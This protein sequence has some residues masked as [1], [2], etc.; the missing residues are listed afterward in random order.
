MPKIS[1]IMAT[2]NRAH[3]LPRA[4]NSVINQT[5]N[6]WELIIINDG[7]T[8]N[9]NNIL[10]EFKDPRIKIISYY[11]NRG[12]A[13]ARNCGLDKMKGEWFTILDS[14]DE[15]IPNALEELLSVP[16]IINKDINAVTCNCID[17]VSGE[18]TGK[19]L[20]HN[21]W[22]NFDKMV[23]LCYGEYWG[24]TKAELLGDLRFNIN[25]PWGE[26]VLWYKL[27]KRAIRY[28]IHKGLRIYH[29]EGTDRLSSKSK[30]SDSLINKKL[31]YYRNIAKE[32]EYLNILKKYRNKEYSEII[33]RVI[34]TFIADSNKNVRE[35]FISNYKFLNF[36][37]ICIIKI[38]YFLGSKIFKRILI[39]LLKNK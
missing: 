12:V 8:D 37:K 28:Y 29:T 17:S 13:Y 3:T 2:Y 18:M 5:F 1:I 25:L 20:N 22:L 39:F 9:T 36:K 24:I 6:D 4:I 26:S 33:Y 31:E 32:N 23:S 15:M 35:L 16:N 30:F 21:Q 27:S 11:P 34:L 38:S 10:L 7:S 14:D 19:G